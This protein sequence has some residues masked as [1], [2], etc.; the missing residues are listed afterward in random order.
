MLVKSCI[1]IF[2]FSLS[3][4]VCAE[5]LR[6]SLHKIESGIPGPTLLVIGG[7]QG[8]EPGG[9]TAA[10]MLVTNYRVQAGS[11]WIVPNLN[12]ES[13][14]KRSRGIHGDMNR[15][16]NVLSKKDP[17]FDE[18]QKIK[19]IILSDDV[20][21]V[22]N[23]HDGSG[24]YKKKYINKMHNPN[25]WGQSIIIDQE[26]M[27]NEKFGNLSSIAGNVQQ[28]INQRLKNKNKFFYVKNTETKKGDVEMEKSLTYFSIKNNRPAFA[29]EASKSF[30]TDERTFYH[31]LAV[32]GFMSELGIK[33]QRDFKMTK[34]DVSKQIGNNLKISLYDN[35]INLNVE[36][37]RR[38]LNYVPL[39]KH[40]S[41]EYKKNNPLIAVINHKK[42][43]KIRYGNRYVTSLKPQYFEYDNGLDS[44]TVQ[45]DG[46]NKK[47]NIGDKVN[48]EKNFRIRASRDYRVNI[49]GYAKRGVTNENNILIKRKD[50]R[51][52]FSIDK[53]EKIFRVELYK[54]DKF[55][56]MILV[57]FSEEKNNQSLSLLNLDSTHIATTH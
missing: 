36:H 2:I 22:L 18:V 50:I 1:S 54:G 10:S 39:K 11:I 7:I 5:P 41:L 47:I 15:K 25:R 24:F 53:N 21:V 35:R 17:E 56:G 55:S 43:L 37:A 29:V 14:I 31:L 45:I 6:F 3:Q 20:D 9:F 28:Y 32:E 46:R 40:S 44:V 8:D 27:S 51:S 26:V 30:L 19:K 57:D 38:Y 48:V 34:R 42:G 12:F 33:F 16:F 52:R 23:L 13:I 4:L 49:I